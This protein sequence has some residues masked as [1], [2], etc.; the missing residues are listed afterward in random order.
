MRQKPTVC[1]TSVRL[2]PS[3][4]TSCS[5]T[6][7]SDVFV[8][9]QFD[10]DSIKGVATDLGT[11]TAH[12]VILARSLSLPAVVGL[13]DIT[14]VAENGQE[15]ILDGLGRAL[16]ASVFILMALFFLNFLQ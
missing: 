15:A 5:E 16:K 11:R 1:S 9:V 14:T 6:E 12:W 13:G 2:S 3:R 10:P 8:A 4:S 7:P